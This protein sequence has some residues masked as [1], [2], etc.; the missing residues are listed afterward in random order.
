MKL[1]IDGFLDSMEFM[2]MFCSRCE[3]LMGQDCY[4]GLGPG[5]KGCRRSWL[6]RQICATLAAAKGEIL[7]DMEAAGCRIEGAA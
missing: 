6:Y 3:M 1:D 4:E 2:D 7:G 5:D